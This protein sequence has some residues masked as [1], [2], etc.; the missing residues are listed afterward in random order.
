M[1][2]ALDQLVAIF[3]ETPTIAAAVVDSLPDEL[4]FLLI[5]PRSIAFLRH[6]KKCLGHFD[7]NLLPTEQNKSDFV[8]A[9]QQLD[10][11]N[12]SLLLIPI[13]DRA[14]RLLH[15][16]DRLNTPRYPIPDSRTFET[17]NDKWQFYQH[18]SELGVRVP[19]TILLGDKA[20]IDFELVCATVGL[21]FVLKPTNRTDGLGVQLIRSKDDLQGKVLSQR[22]YNFAPLIAQSF[23]PGQDIDMSA[24]VD[25]GRIKHFAIQMRKKDALWF[26]KSA[27]FVK[28]TETVVGELSYTGVV[29]IDAR[30]DCRSREI[31][32]IEAN[33]RFWASLAEATAG[34]LN[35]V[36][37][38]I[39][40]SAG[41]EGP[42]PT[43][44]S[45][46]SVPSLKKLLAQILTFKRSYFK[47]ARIDRLRLR[48]GMRIQTRR[49]LS[50]LTR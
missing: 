20:E 29:H 3:G 14:I 31:F 35:F 1:F 16:V 13:D 25:R 23:V 28:L 47:M 15:S 50:L 36:R 40:A 24:L 39:Y 18:C 22:N 44:L 8:R 5:G 11:G 17:L 34:G 26:V 46:V 21:P 2:E 19:H 30:L 6:A 27:D 48:R 12:Q 10:T 49:G 45:E 32:L 43:T 7:N 4:S 33:P 41:L 38:G 37:A 42:D 9:I